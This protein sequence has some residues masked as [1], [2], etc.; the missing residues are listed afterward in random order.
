MAKKRLYRNEK[1]KKI[2]GVCSGISDYFDIEPVIV[3]LIFVL[4]TLFWGVGIFFYILAWIIM[5]T[6]HSKK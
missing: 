4:F 6:K 5:P 1:N 3:R 2:G